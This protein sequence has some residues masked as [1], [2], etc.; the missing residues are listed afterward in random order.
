[1]TGFDGSAYP[2]VLHLYPALSTFWE[3]SGPRI[4]SIV[5]IKWKIKDKVSIMQVG[6]MSEYVY[7]LWLLV[8]ITTQLGSNDWWIFGS[9]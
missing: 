6:L 5:I 3:N 4:Y 9:L 8:D 7:H 2:H 1:M